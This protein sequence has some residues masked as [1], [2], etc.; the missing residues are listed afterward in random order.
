MD[1]WLSGRGK[2]I[3]DTG[4]HGG[5]RRKV[6]VGEEPSDLVWESAVKED[7]ARG[8]EVEDRLPGK[9]GTEWPREEG[10]VQG[11]LGDCAA[12]DTSLRKGSISQPHECTAGRKGLPEGV[13]VRGGRC[14]VAPSGGRA[15]C[16]QVTEPRAQPWG[17]EA[18]GCL[19]DNRL[20]C[21]VDHM[22]S[23]ITIEVQLKPVWLKG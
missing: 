13:S 5:G 2:D 6:V 16:D 15:G 9:G 14:T 11:R 4:T 18:T 8:E 12:L 22:E 7:T 1:E 17:C 19:T 21:L 10:Q 3:S 20:W 23:L